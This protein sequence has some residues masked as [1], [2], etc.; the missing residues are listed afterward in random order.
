VHILDQ[1]AARALKQWVSSV[2]M[3]VFAFIVMPIVVA[4]GMK[5]ASDIGDVM[6]FILRWGYFYFIK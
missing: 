1:A 4:A 6:N 2:L 3:F 5:L